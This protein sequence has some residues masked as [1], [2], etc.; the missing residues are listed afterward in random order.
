MQINFLNNDILDYPNSDDNSG[1]E[2]TTEELEVAEMTQ[3]IVDSSS[4]SNRR[5]PS[6]PTQKEA[7]PEYLALVLLWLKLVD[8]KKV[9]YKI[10]SNR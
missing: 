9:E 2:T 8:F 10:K 4:E 1:E 7:E 6:P 5:T 3:D